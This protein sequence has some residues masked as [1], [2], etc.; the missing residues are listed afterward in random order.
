M[1][2]IV[3]IIV[4]NKIRIQEIFIVRNKYSA[5]NRESKVKQKAK[6]KIKVRLFTFR[7]SKNVIFC[8]IFYVI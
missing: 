5:T 4:P 8:A 1:S 2:Y 3:R 7:I 6:V